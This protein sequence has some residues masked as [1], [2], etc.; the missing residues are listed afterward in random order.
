MLISSLLP[1]KDD[2]AST[3]LKF[4]IVEDKLCLGSCL[5]LAGGGFDIKLS[6]SDDGSLKFMPLICFFK[7]TN[8]KFNFIFAG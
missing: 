2:F 6:K 8:K 7:L 4:G 5:G 3:G 1:K